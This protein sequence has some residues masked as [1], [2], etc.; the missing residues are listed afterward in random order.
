MIT[1]TITNNSS[2]AQGTRG[3]PRV[4]WSL[5]SPS[6]CAFYVSLS[7]DT[8][9]EMSEDW[10]FVQFMSCLMQDKNAETVDM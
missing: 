2:I 3:P 1:I 7:D 5:R 10:I 9:S 4:Q 8:L 6:N